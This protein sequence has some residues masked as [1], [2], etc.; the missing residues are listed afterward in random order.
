MNGELFPVTESRTTFSPPIWATVGLI[1]GCSLFVWAGVWQLDRGAQ[2]RRLFAAFD[3]T[4]NTELLTLPATNSPAT[5]SRYRR[6]E[7]SGEYDAR[8]QILLDNMM[9]KGRSGYYVLTPLRTAT[10]IILVNRGWVPADQN[11]LVLP[12][13]SV[14]QGRHRVTGRLD[15]L[16]RPGVKL[17][18][19]APTADAPWPR[20]LLYP[21]VAEIGE[22]LGDRP[23]EFQVLLDADNADGFVRDWRPAVFGPERHLGY[24]VQWFGL[25]ITLVIIYVVVNRKKTTRD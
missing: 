7:I 9:H 13:V 25:A 22:H 5:D 15:L 17:A 8:H 3:A 4:L 1:V 18:P 14:T 2:K 20:R 10:N 21:S 23:Y 11:R 16:P 19:P 24:A 12:D 6:I